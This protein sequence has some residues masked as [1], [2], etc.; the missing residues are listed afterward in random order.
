MQIAMAGLEVKSQKNRAG[1]VA[2]AP[3][4]AFFVGEGQIL[5]GGDGQQGSFQ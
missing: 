2:Y 5:G 4:N 3:D 1:G